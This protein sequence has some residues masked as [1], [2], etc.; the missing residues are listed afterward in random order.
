MRWNQARRLLLMAG[1]AAALVLVTAPAAGARTGL[2]GSEPADGGRLAPGR[3]AIVLRFTGAVDP[4]LVTVKLSAGQVRAEAGPGYEVGG[5]RRAVEVPLP[6]L[7]AGTWTASWRAVATDGRTLG[8]RLRFTVPT[9]EPAA[10][11]GSVA[12]ADRPATLV[13]AALVGG[14]LVAVAGLLVLVGGLGLVAAAGV[15]GR[16][17]AA[18]LAPAGRPPWR[19]DHLLGAAWVLALTGCVAVLLLHGPTSGLDL[20]TA[21]GSR[22]G[23]VWAGRVLLVAL[24]APLVLLPTGR[25]WSLPCRAGAVALVGLL[26]LTAG[27]SGHA[28]TGDDLIASMVADAHF[29]SVAIWLASLLALGAAVGPGQGAGL[30]RAVPRLTGIEAKAM[31]VIVVSGGL[32]LL[33]H[34]DNPRAMLGTGWGRLLLVKLAVLA[35]LLGVGA[36]TRRWA[37]ERLGPVDDGS[38]PDRLL[39]VLRRMVAVEVLLAGLILALSAALA[40]LSPVLPPASG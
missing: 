28:G 8:G 17:A 3:D 9:P 13:G 26:A 32:R 20:G 22:A 33:A 24:A 16:L 38:P 10:A 1:A 40:N 11:G 27:F 29:G 7:S 36:A 15:P 39:A 37:G 6:S 31:G 34:L 12:A 25:S 4:S 23:R 30:R 2:A 5:D 35:L 19:L 21:L 14:Q 18:T